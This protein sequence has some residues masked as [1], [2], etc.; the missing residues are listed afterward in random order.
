MLTE[1]EKRRIREEEIFRQEVRLS[2]EKRTKS[3]WAKFWAFLNTSFGIWL[4]STVAVGLITWGY[5]QWEEN[6]TK[7]IE[8]RQLI[9]KIDLEIA[10]RLSYFEPK[11]T[12]AKNIWDYSM[13]LAALDN[14]LT[15]T[16]VPIG[17]FPE[18]KQRNLR[19]LLF[20][21]INCSVL[22]F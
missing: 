14:P 20:I 19:S 9:R 2:L 11:L 17:V 16:G 21:F 13:A 7:S 8:N 12:S 5:T 3:K 1:E 18:F 10:A 4:L 22:I 15:P 6:H